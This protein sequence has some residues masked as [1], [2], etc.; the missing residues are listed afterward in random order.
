MDGM[1]PSICQAGVHVVLP[2]LDKVYACVVDMEDN[3]VRKSDGGFDTA[4]YFEHPERY[5]STFSV[6][7]LLFSLY[8]K[9]TVT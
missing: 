8:I 6:K 3:L 5:A 4:E 9:V 1:W 7:V 2:A